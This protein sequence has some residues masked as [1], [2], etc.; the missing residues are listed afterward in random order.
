MEKLV[1]NYWVISKIVAVM[2]T[3]WN[4]AMWTEPFNF[5]KAMVMIIGGSVVTFLLINLLD[6]LVGIIALVCRKIHRHFYDKRVLRFLEQK[7]DEV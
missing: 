3:I 2:L 1:K 5:A 6:M 7:K 4:Y